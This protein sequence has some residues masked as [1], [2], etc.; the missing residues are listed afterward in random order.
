MKN[1]APNAVYRINSS[2]RPAKV[3]EYDPSA[4]VIKTLTPDMTLTD[5][6]CSMLDEAAKHPIVYEDDCPELTPE[7]I[8]KFKRAARIRDERKK[9]TAN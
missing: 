9:K 6:Q 1:P 3:E 8:E 4:M 2:G 7:M 5:E